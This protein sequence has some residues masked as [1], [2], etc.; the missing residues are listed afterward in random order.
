MEKIRIIIG[1]EES[2]ELTVR[3]RERGFECYSCDLKPAK[4]NA[5]WHLQCSI[6]DVI[7]DGWD[8]G[9]F[10]PP[11]TFLTV[12]ANRWLKEQPLRKSGKLVGNAR[13]EAR[14]K[15]IN[16][17]MDLYNANIPHLAIENPIGCMSSI[18]R[19]PDQIIHPCYFGDAAT[20]A[21]CLWLKNLPK[22]KWI[23]END[24]FDSQT[25]VEPKFY[26][27][28]NGKRYPEWSMIEAAKIKDLDLRSEFRSKTFPGIAD[29]IVNQWGSFLHERSFSNCT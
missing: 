19:K 16:F 29:A 21:T 9:I 24:L 28:A 26:T 3:F 20:K 4:I 14:Q 17:F 11:C 22:L 12:T 25:Y 18:F 23:K 5:K 13:Q 6:F 2:Q 8:L 10:H 1:C 15:S 7:N 27:T